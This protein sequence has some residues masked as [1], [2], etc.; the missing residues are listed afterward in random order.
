MLIYNTQTRKKEEFK[1]VKEGYVTMYVCGPTVYNYFHIGN[2]RPFIV[3]DTFR[4]YLKYKG[5]KVK[6]IQNITDID[7]K[8]INKAKEENV[9]FEE[10][11]KRYT[12]AYFEDIKKLKI[13]TADKNPRAT[14]EIKD[15]IELIKILMDKGFAY[16]IDDG[17]YF[18][19]DKFS[20]YGKL[21]NKNLDE[22]KE[23]ARVEVNSQKKNP[24]D[25]ALWKFSKEGEPAW[26]S[27]WGMGRPGWHIECSVM[28]KKYCEAEPIDIHGGGIDLVFPH[29]ENEKAQSEAASG[30]KF[31]NYWMHNGYMNIKGEKMSKSLGNIILA[32]EILKKYSPEVIRLFILSA[33]YRSP[34]DFTWENIEKIKQGYKEIYNTLQ[35]L[36]QL[37]TNKKDIDFKDNEFLNKFFMALDDDFNTP[38]AI[39]VIFN[40]VK[41]AK[42]YLKK[43]LNANDIL[44]L[45]IIEATMKEMCGILKIMPE[46]EKI[47]DKIIE[48]VKQRDKFR[49][50]KKYDEADRIKNEIIDS[51]YELEDTKTKTFILKKM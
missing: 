21:S 12:E 19:V 34:L 39:A 35:I 5:Y 37:E 7:D 27:P 50:E 14:E 28:S 25:F 44:N 10:I 51:G 32:R 36:S 33:H 22:L 18:N 24:L 3:F 4:N 23:G 17:V 11:A 40:L 2:A 1:P 49:K 26:E 41:K 15:M 20:D 30:R 13:E 38:E 46:I 42:D 47:D 16:I 8:I 29:H 9:S 45:K 48:L 6:F 43:E 31:V